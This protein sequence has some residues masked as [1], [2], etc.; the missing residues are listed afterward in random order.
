MQASRIPLYKLFQYQGSA[1][2]VNKF[3]IRHSIKEETCRSMGRWAVVVVV[4]H[5]SLGPLTEENSLLS[6][7]ITTLPRFCTPLLCPAYLYL[8]SQKF[9]SSYS[10]SPA[11]I[12][13]LV[14]L[15]P[16]STT[17]LQANC[18][19][20]YVSRLQIYCLKHAVSF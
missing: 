13:S 3:K 18:V 2:H 15:L 9:L 5:K 20:D 10:S 8:L 17:A 11:V 1:Q 7:C 14:I 16:S 4:V 12:V 19:T 6:S